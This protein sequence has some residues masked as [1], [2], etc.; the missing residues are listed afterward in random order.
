MVV[1]LEFRRNKIKFKTSH[2]GEDC[3]TQTSKKASE[4]LVRLFFSTN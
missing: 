1:R 2:L 4:N 3:I